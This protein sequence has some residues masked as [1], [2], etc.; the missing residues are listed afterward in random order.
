[1]FRLR[2]GGPIIGHLR[3]NSTKCIAFTDIAGIDG[4]RSCPTWANQDTIPQRR[5]AVLS[6]RCLDQRMGFPA[7]AEGALSPFP[8]HRRGDISFHVIGLAAKS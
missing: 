4:V 8:K 2:L 1:M 3:G 6:P 7:V 5:R